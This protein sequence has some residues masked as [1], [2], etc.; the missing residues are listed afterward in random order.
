MGKGREMKN[1][2]ICSFLCSQC[3]FCFHCTLHLAFATF[4]VYMLIFKKKTFKESSNSM[5]K[6]C[7]LCLSLSKQLLS[8]VLQFSSLFY[9][10]KIS[11]TK[12]VLQVSGERKS[13]PL[14]IFA[15]QLPLASQTP[16]VMN[17]KLNFVFAFSLFQILRWEGRSLSPERSV[18][19][20]K[21]LWFKG[22]P[23]CSVF[24]RSHIKSRKL[25]FL[26]DC[27]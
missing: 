27:L 4:L 11:I 7:T 19:T 18:L 20:Q 13:V 16:N 15:Y 21:H 12:T 26:L 8:P 6:C 25:L 1:G 22:F 14:V 5:L 24:R 23:S 17:K 2:I 9:Q 10:C 3:T